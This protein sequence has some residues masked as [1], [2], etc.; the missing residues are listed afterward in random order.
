M[1]AQRIII[2]KEL[3]SIAHFRMIHIVFILAYCIIGLISWSS[4]GTFFEAGSFSLHSLFLTFLTI[5]FFVTPF[6][7][8]SSISDE[9][10][11]GT[12]E[13]LLS[14][15]ITLKE[16]LGGKFLALL[17]VS[18]LFLLPTLVYIITLSFASHLDPAEI[19]CGYLA[20]LLGGCSYIAIGMYASSLTDKPYIAWLTTLGIGSCFQFLFPCIAEWI[21][22]GFGASLF[23]FLSALT[24]FET[25][26]RG[27][28][29]SRDLIYF[30]SLIILFLSLTRWRVC[31][32]KQFSLN[33]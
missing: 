23:H 11:G 12:F 1:S 21:G 33:K 6:I 7:T 13:L 3:K 29:D 5:L 14:K 25:L 19:I 8:M 15:P 9:I 20:L 28:I 10:H 4:Y 2:E 17:I 24:H 16:I 27:V 18:I 30:L 32:L 31:R 22:N 26:S